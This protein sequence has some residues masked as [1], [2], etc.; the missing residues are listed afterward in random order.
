MINSNFYLQVLIN[1]VSK[2]FVKL[3]DY[4]QYFSGTYSSIL[5]EHVFMFI[6][7]SLIIYS[8]YSFRK[9]YFY[10]NSFFF[11]RSLFS[12]YNLSLSYSFY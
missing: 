9:P 4:F 2:V 3:F 6:F 8:N 12:C 10:F 11:I 1:K 5:K 7:E